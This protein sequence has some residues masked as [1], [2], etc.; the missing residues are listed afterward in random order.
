MSIHL[1]PETEARLVAWANALGVSVD[2][3]LETLIERDLSPELHDA[4]VVSDAQLQ[5]EHGIWV[6][7]T[8]HPMPPSLVEDTLEAMRLEREASLLGNI[9][10]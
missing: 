1:R 5:K 2:D 3:Y 10:G 9:P 8:G 7:R 4:T 6:Y